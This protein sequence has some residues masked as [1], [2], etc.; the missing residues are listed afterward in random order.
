M[1]ERVGAVVERD[2]SSGQGAEPRRVGGV[3][4]DPFDCRVLG[5]SAASSDHPHQLAAL[6][7]QSGGGGTDRTGTD[8]HMQRH[9]MTPSGSRFDRRD[10]SRHSVAIR[11]FS[12]R[13][14][15]HGTTRKVFMRV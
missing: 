1:V 9:D 13:S 5:A 8:D 7:E 12:T 14:R 6:G 2:G 3:R 10:S 4:S 15:A 11:T